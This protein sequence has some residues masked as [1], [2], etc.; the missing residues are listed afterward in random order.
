MTVRYDPITDKFINDGEKESI[1]ATISLDAFPKNII[2]MNV[3]NVSDDSINKIADAVVQKLRAEHT[4]RGE[5]DDKT[6][7][8][9]M[10]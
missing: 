6:I 9:Q 2:Q 4:E 5:S 3:V 10:R 7:L 8:R 1:T